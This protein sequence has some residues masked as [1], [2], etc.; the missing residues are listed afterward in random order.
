MACILPFCF[1]VEFQNVRC[2]VI[3]RAGAPN[4]NNVKKGIQDEI[5]APYQ[6]F[7]FGCLGD[8]G[9]KC[10]L[11]AAPAWQTVWVPKDG[12]AYTFGGVAYTIDYSLRFDVRT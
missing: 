7:T 12:V 4:N 9:C 1:K 3:I 2:R 6:D 11:G 10:T 5:A 8:D